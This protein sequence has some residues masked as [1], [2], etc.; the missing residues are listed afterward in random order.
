MR[1]SAVVYGIEVEVW[2]GVVWCGED[3][4]DLHDEMSGC[5]WASGAVLAWVDRTAVFWVLLRLYQ[6]TRLRVM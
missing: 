1:G 6:P 2:C 3:E 4:E 5:F